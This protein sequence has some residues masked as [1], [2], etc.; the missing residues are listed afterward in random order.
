MKKHYFVSIF[1]PEDEGYWVE[2]PDLEGCFTQGDTLEETMQMATDALYAW[3]TPI[4][5]EPIK[6][7]PTP[8]VP[9]SESLSDGAFI[10]MIEFDPVRAAKLNNK[11]AVKKTLTIPAWLDELAKENRIN[12]SQTLQQALIDKLGLE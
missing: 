11:K 7:I 4:D 12:Y 1:H 3:F 6:E 9:S 5:G 2:F 10:M 8:S